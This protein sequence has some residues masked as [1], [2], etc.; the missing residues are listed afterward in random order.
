MQK[1]G[2]AVQRFKLA[3]NAD[4][5]VAG[6]KYLLETGAEELVIK[7]CIL[8]GGR[9]KGTFDRRRFLGQTQFRTTN[10]RIW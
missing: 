2:L 6:G 10:L 1:H 5:A 7:A 9:G 4:E 3:T 8:A